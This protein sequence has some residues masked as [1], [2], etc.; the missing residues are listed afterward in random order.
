MWVPNCNN[1]GL[2]N[3]DKIECIRIC[4]DY[5]R[6]NWSIMA[7]EYCLWNCFHSA[8][9]AYAQ[10]AQLMDEIE[11]EKCT[12]GTGLFMPCPLSRASGASS[13]ICPSRTGSR[14]LSTT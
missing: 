1:T 6:K 11:K 14:T 8:E 4:S 5:E 9:D 12:A 10:L 13:R 3:L 7:D 2:I